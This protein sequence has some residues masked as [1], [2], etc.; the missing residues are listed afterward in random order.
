MLRRYTHTLSLVVFITIFTVLAGI[1][2]FQTSLS[3]DSAP[4]VA[5]HGSSPVKIGKA[6]ALAAKKKRRSVAGP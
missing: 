3:A 2:I 1:K 4:E 6:K 5:E